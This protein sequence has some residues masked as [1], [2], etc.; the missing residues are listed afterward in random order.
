LHLGT[1]NTSATA[2]AAIVAD[3]ITIL[4][5]NWVDYTN[6]TSGTRASLANRVAANTT[7]NAAFI[8]GIVQTTSTLGYSGGVENF[9]RFL[10]EWTNLTLTYNGSMVVM[11][12]SKYAIAKWDTINTYYNPP[13]RMWGFDTNFRDPLRLPPGTPTAYSLVRGSWTLTAAQ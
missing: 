7:V 3:A 1:T 13:V 8:A 10:E 12:E 9:P 11:F 5:A 6:G 4:S 2:P